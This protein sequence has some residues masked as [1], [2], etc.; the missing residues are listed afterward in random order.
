MSLAHESIVG[1][2]LG[3]H[4]TIDSVTSNF[5]WPGITNDITRLCKSCDPCQRTIPKGKVSK[6]PLGEMPI[7]GDTFER[8][9]V[10]LVGAIN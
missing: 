7:I 8:V 2:H 10:D 4:K 3:V 6:V 1:G 5:H 9:A